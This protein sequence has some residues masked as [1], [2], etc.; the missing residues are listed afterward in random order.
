MKKILLVVFVLL[1]ISLQMQAQFTGCAD[2]SENPTVQNAAMEQ[3]LLDLVNAERANVSAPLLV[4]ADQLDRAAR[5]HAEDM[6][7]EGY[8]HHDSYD[9]S[10]RPSTCIAGG[11]MGTKQCNRTTRI[12]NF[13]LGTNVTNEEN[14]AAGWSSPDSV[15]HAANELG[16]M[17]HAPHRNIM[18][19]T[20]WTEVGVAYYF[21][22][23]D[24]YCTHYWVM[25]FG[26]RDGAI[27]SVASD[28]PADFSISDPIPN[29]FTD[30][31]TFTLNIRE[32]QEIRVEL[33]NLLGQQ[34]RQ[35]H[36]GNLAA[37][38]DH[39]LVID[40]NELEEGVYFCLIKGE[41]FETV[42]KILVRDN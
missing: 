35:I 38:S 29:P 39:T 34:L 6:A 11:A 30:Q 37:G 41:R 40:R 1:C 3:D 26:N 21:K 24:S 28:E 36:Q 7:E 18:L 4:R 2:G 5:Y 25:N 20:T 12:N 31:S 13:Y 22:S 15:V 9:G 32:S 42:K 16:W 17:T 27:S 33:Y 8:F 10:V 14:L 19:D 23:G